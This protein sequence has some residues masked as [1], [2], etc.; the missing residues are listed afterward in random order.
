MNK[1]IVDECTGPLVASW[2][3]AKGFDVFSVAENSPGITDE[4]VLKKAVVEKRILI[5]N[6]KDFGEMIFKNNLPHKGVIFM[7]LADERSMNKIAVL[8]KLMHEQPLLLADNNF[9]MVLTEKN[10]R[11]NRT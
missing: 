4:E 8:E 7:R 3:M 2:L 1:F 5:T 9:F 10:I 6:D 11:I